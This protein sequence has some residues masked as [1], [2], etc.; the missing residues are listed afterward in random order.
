MIHLSDLSGPTKT[1]KLSKEWSL[2]CNK[3]FHEQ[4]IAEA[5]LE[6]PQTPWFKDLDNM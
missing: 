5:K 2:K 4:Y 3:E 1:W 6:I